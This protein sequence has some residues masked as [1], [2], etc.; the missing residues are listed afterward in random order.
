MKKTTKKELAA[1]ALRDSSMAV[2]T[3]PSAPPSVVPK[4]TEKQM[5]R[6]MAMAMV[7]DAHA[8]QKQI[9]TRITDI[10][11]LVLSASIDAI[12]KAV[13]V[14]PCHFSI[15]GDSC[16]ESGVSASGFVPFADLPE[17]VKE[18]II[19]RSALCK[20]KDRLRLKF[21]HY[22]DYN[23]EERINKVANQ[24]QTIQRDNPLVVQQL[25]AGEAMRKKLLDAGENLLAC[26]KTV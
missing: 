5:F 2:A 22:G 3:T 19:E 23:I 11:T 16:R 15:Y 8:Q 21:G 4:P 9:E 24:L 1:Q 26:I 14:N 12:S 25:L 18:L 6:A 13:K 10:E 17:K 20:E 7:Q